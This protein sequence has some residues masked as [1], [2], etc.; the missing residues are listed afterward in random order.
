MSKLSFLDDEPSESVSVPDAPAAEAVVAA[1]EP[2]APAAPEPIAPAQ[3]RAPDGKFAPKTAAEAAEATAQPQPA[4]AP[5]PTAEAGAAAAPAVPAQPIVPATPEPGHVPIA[6]LLDEREK[7]QALEGRIAAFEA[8]KAKAQAE[9]EAKASPPPGFSDDPEGHLAAREA[10]L[11]WQMYAMRRDLSKK[12]AVKEY[13]KETVEEAMA[14][15]KEN[16]AKDPEFNRQALLSDDPTEF[17]IDAWKRD[18]VLTQ[19]SVGDFDEY[20]AWKAAKAV[21]ASDPALI[22]AAP[23][24][25]PLAPAPTPPRSLATQ[26]SAAGPAHVAVH[27]GAAYADTFK[28]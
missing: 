6:A 3:P 16:A 10:E 19:L 25:V 20:L 8:E 2:S 17:A 21:P 22:A 23:A 5:T 14:W 7:R 13:G 28:G 15:A 27:D 9:A 1:P 26:P 11:Q 24:A 12:F 4:P 18:K